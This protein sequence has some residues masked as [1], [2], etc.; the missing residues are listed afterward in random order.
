MKIAVGLLLIGVAFVAYSFSVPAYTDEKV[1]M[2]RY[3]AMSAGQSAEYWKLRDQMLTPKYKLQDYGGTLI[4]A[5]IGI[6]AL[7]RKDRIRAPKSRLAVVA[8]ALVAP[9]VSVGA[10]VFDLLQGHRRGEFPRWADSLGIPLMG[11]PVQLVVMLLWA[12]THLAF[13]RN[14]YSPE[15]PLALALSRQSNKWLLVISSITALLITLCVAVGT[16]WYAIPGALWLYIYLSLAAGRRAAGE[17]HQAD[18]AEVP[19]SRAGD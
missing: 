4:T 16:Y 15:A 18:A 13:L 7:T 19:T 17:T 9:F 2:E 5:G 1:F 10:F 6:L 14:A 12:I 3:M 11:V 8:L